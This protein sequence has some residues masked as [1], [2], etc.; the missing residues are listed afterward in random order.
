[1]P[2]QR[3]RLVVISALLTFGVIV[4]GVLAAAE[5]KAAR[6]ST[7]M[8]EHKRA[9]H[10]LQRLTFGPRPGDVDRVAALGVDRWIDQ[11]L[12]PDKID[13]KTL[14]PRLAAFR[15]LHMDTR[16]MMENFPPPQV[17]KAVMD[18]KRPMP[19]D[20]VKRA[21]YQAQIE[22]IQEKKERK[23]DTATPTSVTATDSAVP[24]PNASNTAQ[25]ASDTTSP[26]KGKLTDEQ[27][28]QRRE[29]RL[30]ADLKAQELLDRP[31]DER[32]KEVLQ[33]S[34]GAAGAFEFTQRSEGRGVH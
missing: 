10:A 1:M 7:H 12:H 2:I 30:Y 8:D 26:R 20:P 19:S 24:D 16:E 33:M 5:K 13:D 32:M 28:A 3:T 11:Q 31:A 15:T 25:E 34:G 18:G 23:E 21:V 27:L 4:L 29:D 9:L 22:R 14:E 6:V 17:I